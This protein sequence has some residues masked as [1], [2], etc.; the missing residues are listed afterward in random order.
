VI[1][2][3]VNGELVPRGSVGTGFN[4]Q[5]LKDLHSRL[6]KIVRKTS[7]L[8][9][10]IDVGSEVTWVEPKYVCQVKYTEITDD[11][12][13]RHPSFLGLRSDK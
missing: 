3:N 1:A 10:E 13:V 2:K 11:G 9:V 4:E 12:N 7:P 8:K 6:S 5:A